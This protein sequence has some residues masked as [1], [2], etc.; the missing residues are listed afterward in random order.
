MALYELENIRHHYNGTPV[1]SIDRFRVAENSVTGLC[2][3]NGS[4]KTTLL[5]LLG[6]IAPPAAGFIYFR[7]H[8]A[9]PYD[10]QIRDKVALLPQQS[11]LLKRSVYQNV[12][13]GLRIRKNTDNESGRVAHALSLVGL[14]PEK[15]AG[16]PWYAL[17]GGEAR[18]VAMAARLALR[19]EV[20]L[21]DE[22][23]T[24]VDAASA[25]LMREAAAEA[26]LQWNT[27]LIIAS[28]DMQWLQGICHDLVYLFSGTILGKG[29][30]TIVFGPWQHTSGGG[31]IRTLADGQVLAAENAPKDLTGTA[32]ILDPD[33]M[34][35]HASPDDTGAK[36]NTLKGRIVCLDMEQHTGFIRVL[37]LAGRSE[38]C[39]YLDAQTLSAR[40][41][42][43]GSE[44]WL[45]YRPDRIEWKAPGLQ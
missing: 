35:L 15:F 17:S 6:L 28:H 25:Q 34:S 21:L 39:L 44:V 24:S 4:G 22:P 18:R 23:T 41:W 3:P 29:K 19:P 11:F 12:A 10:G 32:A 40:N 14:N 8:R 45:A 1:L 16:R 9:R 42:Q 27:S 20:L 7:G 37:V 38:F 5:S 33:D 13:Y 2:G 43:P 31:A 30:K 26:H 36:K